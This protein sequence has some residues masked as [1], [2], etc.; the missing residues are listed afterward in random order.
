MTLGISLIAIIF[1]YILVSSIIKIE[2]HVKQHAKLDRIINR[3]QNE[4]DKKVKV[5][6]QIKI[7]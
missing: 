1:A 7:N 6:R 3:N 5:I 4:L 2:G